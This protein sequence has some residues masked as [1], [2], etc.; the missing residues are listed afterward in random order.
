MHYRNFITMIRLPNWWGCKAVKTD[1]YLYTEWRK[2]GT[3][4]HR[5]LFDH[6]LDPMENTN[7]A[8]KPDAQPVVDRLS[9]L[10]EPQWKT[11]P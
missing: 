5:M 3:I 8:D 6:E 2:K 11:K 1:R 9:A 10:L 4:T 7:I